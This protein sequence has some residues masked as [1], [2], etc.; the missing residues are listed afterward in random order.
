MQSCDGWGAGKKRRENY[1]SPRCA[2]YAYVKGGGVCGQKE[3]LIMRVRCAPAYV[4]YHE[5]T[6]RLVQSL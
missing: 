1:Q 5:E 3:R 2:L 4:V 6:S